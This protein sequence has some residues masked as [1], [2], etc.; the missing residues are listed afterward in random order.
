M[1]EAPKVE[2]VND[3][4]LKT[5]DQRIAQRNAVIQARLQPTLPIDDPAN[6]IPEDE[7]GLDTVELREFKVSELYSPLMRMS[8]LKDLDTL[9]P[10]SG[11]AFLSEQYF[12]DLENKYLNRYTIPLIGKS[13]E[14]LAKERYQREKYQSFLGEVSGTIDDLN[15]L[16]P[17]YAK[18]LK[19]EFQ[20]AQQQYNT[21]FK[22]DDNRFNNP[23]AKY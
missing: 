18:E 23:D 3:T 4:P 11:G 15:N 20:D 8:E 16:N 6:D 1:E 2:I 14:Q 17:E 21:N 12:S 5:V 19:K 13:Q 22:I 9:D 7:L 10:S